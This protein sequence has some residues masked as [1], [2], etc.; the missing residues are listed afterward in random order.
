[1]HSSGISFSPCLPHANI[2]C[3]MAVA[4]TLFVRASTSWHRNGLARRQNGIFCRAGKSIVHMLL[5]RGHQITAGGL[6]LSRL[7]CRVDHVASSS[8]LLVDV[9]VKFIKH[10]RK[11]YL[12]L[13]RG[14]NV[15]F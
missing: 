10:D 9:L 6:Q 5:L 4:K 13:G 14:R 8:S 7:Y 11:Y 1:M 2:A 3:T 12:K 15:Q